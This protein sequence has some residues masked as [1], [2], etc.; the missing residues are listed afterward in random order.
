MMNPMPLA[1]FFFL[2]TFSA[3]A[4]TISWNFTGDVLTG[5]SS[6]PSITALNASL[7]AGVSQSG[8]PD[9][10]CSNGNPWSV[11]GWYLSPIGNQSEANAIANNDYVQF[12][13]S[14]PAGTSF[15]VS[16]FSFDANRSVNTAMT[17]FGPLNWSIRSSADNY[18][19]T[20]ASGTNPNG[21]TNSGAACQTNTLGPNIQMTGPQTLYFRIYA[22]GEVTDNIVTMRFDNVLIAGTV[23]VELTEWRAER[24]QD[25]VALHWTTATE[26]ENEAFIIERS[27]DAEHFDPIGQLPGA[28]QSVTRQAYRFY[29]N[30]P[31]PG[32]NYYRLQ[33]RDF[34][35]QMHVGPVLSIHHTDAAQWRIWPQPVA[36]R[37]HVDLPE[38]FDEP[39]AWILSDFAGRVFL[40][41]SIPEETSGFA[42][43]VASLPPGIYVLQ[44]RSSAGQ[45][46]ATVI[47]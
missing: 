20:L 13:I 4:Q 35:G 33:Q 3:S 18:A 15:F 43:D 32:I 31:L 41:G 36:D 11:R 10:G 42:L 47:K 23:P 27:G 46:A 38:T 30:N 16:N 26:T 1:A 17:D 6:D 12:G 29:D 8:F 21:E 7:G 28:G 44:L 39:A 24:E 45:L 19:T 37:L 2:F 34:D 9:E 22:W 25:R 5:S 40:S 14:I